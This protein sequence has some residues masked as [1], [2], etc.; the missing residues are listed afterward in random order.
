MRL[1]ASLE[2]YLV[3][4]SARGVQIQQLA[5]IQ[6]SVKRINWA[7]REILPGRVLDE[8]EDP[9]SHENKQSGGRSAA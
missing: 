8:Y 1:I 9:E 5:E 7:L 2:Y 6:N 4:R 3:S